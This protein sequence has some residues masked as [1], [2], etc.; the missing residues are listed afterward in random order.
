V[1]AQQGSTWLTTPRHWQ[2]AV[3]YAG[4]SSDKNAFIFFQGAWE[5]LQPRLPMAPS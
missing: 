4:A 2:P 3:L 1:G 5:V